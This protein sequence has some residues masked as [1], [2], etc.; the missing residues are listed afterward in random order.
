MGFTQTKDEK[1]N[2]SE[3]F[4]WPFFSSHVEGGGESIERR[5]AGRN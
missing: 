2:L 1:E 3:S 5:T 4:P